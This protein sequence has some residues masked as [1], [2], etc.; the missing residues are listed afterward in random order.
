MSN[1][2]QVIHIWKGQM[3]IYFESV[4]CHEFFGADTIVSI[5]K[6]FEQEWEA[7]I[8]RFYKPIREREGKECINGKEEIKK[9]E[10]SI[11]V[12]SLA[13]ENNL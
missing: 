5:L 9:K 6:N 1:C 11:H 4:K 7:I 2:S 12:I 10:I 3:S 13:V 8:N